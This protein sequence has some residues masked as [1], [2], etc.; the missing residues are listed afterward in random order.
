MRS[1]DANLQQKA[2]HG[3]KWQAI[4]IVGRQILS[5]VVFTTLARL[6]D[7]SAFGLLGLVGVYLALVNVFADQGISAALVQRS[8]L[9]DGH[10]DSAFF[11]VVGCATF[12]CLATVSAAGLLARFFAEPQLATLLRWSSLSLIINALGGVHAAQFARELNF[13]PTA[14]R[15]MVGNLVGGAVGVAMAFG[16]YGVWALVGQQLA[17]AVAGVV[18]LWKKSPWRP[19]FNFRFRHLR[20][21]MAISLPVF[22]T[23]LIWAITGRADQFLIGKFLGPLSLGFYSAATR[24]GDLAKSSLFQPLGAVAL[25]ALSR[26][27]DDSGRFHSAIDR[28]LDM[29]A[30]LSLPCLL[31]LSAVATQ[32]IPLLLGMKWLE[33]GMMLQLLAVW[34]LLHGFWC[35]AHYA[36]LASG[37]AQATFY[38]SLAHAIGM[39]IGCLAGLQFGVRGVLFGLIANELLMNVPRLYLFS[40]YTGYSPGRYL[41]PFFAPALAAGG[42][43]VTVMH[44]GRAMSHG[45]PSWAVLIFQCLAGAATYLVLIFALCPGRLRNAASLTAIAFHRSRVAPMADPVGSS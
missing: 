14:L 10:L 44:I 38:I 9:S 41:R 35:I 32:L 21:I 11:F 42:M 27:K 5:L 45:G 34:V 6:L 18:F 16:G 23:S 30:M 8:K 22:A 31:G 36:M 40:K 24:V 7:P 4:E 17:G 43:V 26:V 37:H 13:R 29:N 19:G 3:L 2:V 12:L 39:V 1:P 33:S 28:A 25:P 15:A 20:E